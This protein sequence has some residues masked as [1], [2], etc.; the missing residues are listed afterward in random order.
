MV[1][2]CLA[3]SFSLTSRQSADL[4]RTYRSFPKQTHARARDSDAGCALSLLQLP[5][6]H[7]SPL[8]IAQEGA[9]TSP[10]RAQD[11]SRAR[12]GGLPVAAGQPGAADL[13]PRGCNSQRGAGGASRPPLSSR[14]P[15]SLLQRTAARPAPSVQRCSRPAAGRYHS[16]PGRGCPLPR[17][18][19]TPLCGP[20]AF[21]LQIDAAPRGCCCQPRANG[22][23]GLFPVI[24]PPSKQNAACLPHV[25]EL[26]KVT[27]CS[28]CSV[29]CWLFSPS[30]RCRKL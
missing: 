18:A 1:K 3:P 27:E 14:R 2:S 19:W 13:Q 23:P 17:N 16:L 25:V 12:G 10:A 7:S 8:P 20:C 5:T 30:V 9:C 26:G 15:E 22:G 29:P 11:G 21:T 24:S 28:I 4:F 6:R